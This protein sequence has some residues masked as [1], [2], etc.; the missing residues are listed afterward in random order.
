MH[1][2]VDV[3]GRRNKIRGGWKSLCPAHADR[4][5]SL[6]ITDGKKGVQ[7]YCNSHHCNF[8]DIV[9]AAGL[10]PQMLFFD[11]GENRVDAK[12]LAEARKQRE[13][14]EERRKQTRI[15]MWCIRFIR[16]GYT[17]E[18]EDSDRAAIIACSVVLSN[19]QVNHWEAI[20][21]TH[22]ERMEASRYCM[23]QG[24]LPPVATERWRV[25]A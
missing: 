9:R 16:N 13:E 7:L 6:S 3:N 23:E 2:G 19:K 21:D 17:Q 20:L 5:P 14:E 8:F 12:K 1:F 22:L 11:Y 24:M 4:T 18:D 15:G 10:T 25:A